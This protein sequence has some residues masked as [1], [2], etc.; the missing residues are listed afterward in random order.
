[1]YCTHEAVCRE[2][3]T[4]R[5]EIKRELRKEYR[6]KHK[7]ERNKGMKTDQEVRKE[8]GQEVKTERLLKLINQRKSL[9]LVLTVMNHDKTDT[10]NRRSGSKF[11]KPASR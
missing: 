10:T 6:K 8:T 3:Q 1:M 9:D 5:G 2:K 11:R 7:W 4:Y